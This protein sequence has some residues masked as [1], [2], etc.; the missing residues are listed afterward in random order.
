MAILDI[1]FTTK[2]TKENLLFLIIAYM[3]SITDYKS[4]F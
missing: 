3:E 1:D 4:L 2:E